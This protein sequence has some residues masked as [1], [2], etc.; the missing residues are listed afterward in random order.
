MSRAFT[1]QA[2]RRDPRP[3]TTLE[4]ILMIVVDKDLPHISNKQIYTCFDFRMS[5]PNILYN[6]YP[7]YIAAAIKGYNT[8]YTSE[9]SS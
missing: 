2:L 8:G 5:L 4:K 3:D 1:R 9:G 7:P 6:K